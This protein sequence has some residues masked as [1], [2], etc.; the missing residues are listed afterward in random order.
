ML[1]PRDDLSVKLNFDGA[2]TDE[3]SNTKPFMVELT[4]LHDGSVRAITYPSR[5]ARDYFGGYAPIYHQ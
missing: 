5:L 4:T 2:F 1:T 3:N